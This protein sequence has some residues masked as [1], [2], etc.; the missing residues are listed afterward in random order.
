VDGLAGDADVPKI[1]AQLAERGYPP[2]TIAM[3]MGEN[4]LGVFRTVLKP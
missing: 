1:P 3:I 4:S 2:D